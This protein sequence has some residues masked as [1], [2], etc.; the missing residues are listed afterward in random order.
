MGLLLLLFLEFFVEVFLLEMTLGK[1]FSR[2]WHSALQLY[3]RKNM[4]Y[5]QINLCRIRIPK[6]ECHG[7]GCSKKLRIFRYITFKLR[8]VPKFLS[9]QFLNVLKN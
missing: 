9:F 6:T 4:L 2:N 7:P 8:D 1:I 3:K 5:R